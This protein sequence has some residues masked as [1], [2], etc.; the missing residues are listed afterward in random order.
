LMALPVP[1]LQTWLIEAMT[2]RHE[3][4]TGIR[5]SYISHHTTARTFKS[6]SMEELDAYIASLQGAIQAKL[7]GDTVAARRP[8]HPGV[9]YS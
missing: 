2:A 1:T 6:S 4:A 9:G 5:V 7:N 3:I 8:I